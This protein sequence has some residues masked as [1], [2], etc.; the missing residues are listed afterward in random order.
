MNWRRFLAFN[1]LGGA[2]WV[3]IWTTVG[4]YLDIHGSHI[5]MLIHKLGLLGVAIAT[6]TLMAVMTHV[7]GHKILTNL[8][9]SVADKIEER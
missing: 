9:H 8:R 3:L 2:L 5:A 4:Y 7:Y 1:A 6:I